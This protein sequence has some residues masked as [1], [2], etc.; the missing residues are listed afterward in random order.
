MALSA[1]PSASQKQPGGLRCHPDVS[2]GSPLRGRTAG[3]GDRD[4]GR[5]RGV[6]ESES[7]WSGELLENGKVMFGGFYYGKSMSNVHCHMSRDHFLW[8]F[9]FRA[10]HGN[11]V[12]QVFVGKR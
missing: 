11:V 3:D 5:F 6:S 4:R 10:F 1:I 9:A 2:H 12:F 7:R 8:S